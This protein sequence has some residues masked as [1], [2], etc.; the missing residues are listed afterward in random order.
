METS[1]IINFIVN[2]I[3][4]SLVYMFITHLWRSFFYYNVIER[5]I[6][7]THDRIISFLI[8]NREF[9]RSEHH[10]CCFFNN[11]EINNASLAM[12]RMRQIKQKIA[13]LERRLKDSKE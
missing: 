2:L 4:F 5:K 10:K 7:F 3:F 1:I 9:Y 6:E 13:D 12:E 11:D 8:D